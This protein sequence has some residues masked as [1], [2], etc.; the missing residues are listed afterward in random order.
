MKIT[1][2]GAAGEVTGSSSLVET[3]EYKILIDCG[4]F[5][6]NDFNVAKNNNPLPFN[7]T[8]LTHVFITHAHL[9]HTGRLPLLVKLGYTGNFYATAPTLELAELVMRD[10]HK[11]MLYDNKKTGRPILYDENDIAGVVGQG[12]ALEYGAP[13]VI[14]V[15]AN[16]PVSPSLVRRGDALSPPARGGVGLKAGGG[17]S[18]ITV[19][20]HD[21]GHIF[22]SAFIEIKAEGKKVVFSGDVGNIHVPILRDTEA[23]PIGLDLL[24]CESTYG[25]R[26][27]EATATREEMIE[28]AILESASR[29]GVLMIPSFAL[30]RT[31]ELIYELNKLI[32]HKHKLTNIP[33]FLDSPLAIDAVKVYRK[34]PKYYD[35]KASEYFKEGDDIFNFSTLNTTYSREESMKINH[36]PGPKV[37]IAGAGMMNGGRILHHALRYLSDP[38]NTI[39]FIGYQSPGTLGH[40]IQSGQSPVTVLGENVEVNCKIKAIGALSAHGDQNKLVS[41]ISVAKPKKVYFNH[42]DPAASSA[43]SKRLKQEYNIEAGAVKANLS[44]TL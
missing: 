33:I 23:L 2:F 41:W 35:E 13:M 43:V 5:Q 8:E 10:A 12:K 37:I 28:Q 26:V 3:G 22:G 7:P 19:T 42:G 40:H 14:G 18:V 20:F 32:D 21:V 4:M 16:H 38:K 17:G 9:D 29:G 36:T 30:E 27:H 44:I 15:A 25:D 24:V 31:Q 1:F 39:L 11:I 6:G 34:Y